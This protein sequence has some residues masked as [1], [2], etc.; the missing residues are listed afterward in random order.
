[1]VCPSCFCT[2]V[3]DAADVTGQHAERSME[4]ASCFEFDFT[5]VH[6]G[7]VRQS[8]LRVIGIDTR[9][10]SGLGMTS[11]TRRIAWAADVVSRGAPTVLTL[12]R[13]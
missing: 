4:W 10:N 11:S 7:S 12:P 8:G 5:F 9:T 1:M 3:G 13:R 2:R 6:E